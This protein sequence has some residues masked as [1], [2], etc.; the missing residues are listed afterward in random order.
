MGAKESKT[1]IAETSTHA[2]T[3]TADVERVRI[4]EVML[5]QAYNDFVALFCVT[6]NGKYVLSC[7]FEG[8]FQTYLN[9][10]GLKDDVD[11]WKKQHGC[12]YVS[13][14]FRTFKL[15]GIRCMQV[16]IGIELRVWPHED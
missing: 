16:L 5:L 7:I 13:S 14:R 3:A 11:F 4:I 9:K 12:T 15:D 8:A 10:I 6:G 2:S 1:K